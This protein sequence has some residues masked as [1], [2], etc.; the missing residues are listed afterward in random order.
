VSPGHDRAPL[1]ADIEPITAR[2]ALEF[3]KMVAERRYHGSATG[4]K[5]ASTAKPLSVGRSDDEHLT[6]LPK[7]L[8][9]TAWIPI[10]PLS[11][12]PE[13][14]GTTVRNVTEINPAALEGYR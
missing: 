7:A 5:R 1:E 2:Q 13:L 6:H 12:E 10:D 4:H 14:V 3:E 8:G 11:P 9:E